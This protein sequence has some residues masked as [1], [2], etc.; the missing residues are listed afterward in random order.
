[1]NGVGPLAVFPERLGDVERVGH[2]VCVRGQRLGHTNGVGHVGSSHGGARIAERGRPVFPGFTPEITG[3]RVE[4]GSGR[5]GLGLLDWGEET[6]VDVTP[7]VLLAG[8]RFAERLVLA[9]KLDHVERGL[10]ADVALQELF[11]VLAIV[12]GAP[13]T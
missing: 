2:V 9:G 13:P 1:M 10:P 6:A 8:R 11:S 5:Q 12:H 7:S 3:F 4:P